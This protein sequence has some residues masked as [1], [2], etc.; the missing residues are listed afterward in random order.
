MA[1]RVLDLEGIDAHGLSYA[2]PRGASARTVSAVWEH[3]GSTRSTTASTALS[4]SLKAAAAAATIDALSPHLTKSNVVALKPHIG[5]TLV[6]DDRVAAHRA[7]ERIAMNA[8]VGPHSG[9]GSGAGLNYCISK[10]RGALEKLDSFDDQDTDEDND[11]DYDK[12][13]HL[14]N[15]LMATSHGWHNVPRPTI[16]YDRAYE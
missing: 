16:E 9:V 2:T 3:L 11:E 14:R 5:H 15:R 13:R 10:L 12:P 7:E 8:H 6:R 4:P 1:A